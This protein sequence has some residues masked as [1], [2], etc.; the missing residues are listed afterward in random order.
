MSV[1]SV[2]MVSALGFD[3]LWFGLAVTTAF[4]MMAV[5]KQESA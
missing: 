2:P 5:P 4:R 1:F 3:L